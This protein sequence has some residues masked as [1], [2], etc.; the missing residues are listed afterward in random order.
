[1]APACGEFVAL[2]GRQV[3]DEIVQEGHAMGAARSSAGRSQGSRVT[4]S[5]GEATARTT[6][7]RRGGS[8]RRWGGIG[9]RGDRRPLAIAWA[10]ERAREIGAGAR[11]QRTTIN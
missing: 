3:R 5:S 8:T 7:A 1:M 6:T 4:A 9:W 10:R 2:V 11:P